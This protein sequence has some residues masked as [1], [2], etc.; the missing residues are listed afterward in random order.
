[1]N[2]S[3]ARFNDAS[4]HFINLTTAAVGAIAGATFGIGLALAPSAGVGTME[5]YY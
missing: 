2:N 1:V 4:G 3:P 5:S